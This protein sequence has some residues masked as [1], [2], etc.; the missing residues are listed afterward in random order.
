MRESGEAA[1]MKLSKLIERVGDD[2][3]VLQN[4][5]HSSPELQQCKNDGRVSFFTDKAKV[6]DLIRQAATGEKGQWTALV[7]WL[8]T[9]K[10]P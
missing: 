10:L 8:P 6:N 9:D 2:N 3:V 4:I 7:V 5:L 1:S